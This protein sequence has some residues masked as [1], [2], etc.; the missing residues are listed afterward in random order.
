MNTNV[1]LPD[2]TVLLCSQ[3]YGMEHIL[4]NLY[5]DTYEDILMGKKM[6]QIYEAANGSGNLQLLCRKCIA[7]RIEYDW[8]CA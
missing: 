7:A 3:D 6:Q 4:G 5:L 1:V 2:G 8:K